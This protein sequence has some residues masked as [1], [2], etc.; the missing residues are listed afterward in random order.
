MS[1]RI[2]VDRSF[3]SAAPY[4]LLSAEGEIFLAPGGLMVGWDV[5]SDDYE[6]TSRA[7]VDAACEQLAAAYQ[8]LGDGDLTHMIFHRVPA[9]HY[10]PREF[11]A[12]A[13][14]LIDDERRAAFEAGRY[15]HTLVRCYLTHVPEPEIRSRLAASL[16]SG[17]APLGRTAWRAIVDQFHERMLSFEDALAGALRVKR[18]SSAEMFQDLHLCLTGLDHPFALP[19]EPVHLNEVLADQTFYGGLEPAVGELYLRPV[20]IDAYPSETIPQMLGL[21][22]SHPGRLMLSVRFICMDSYTAQRQLRLARGHWARSMLGPL[23]MVLEAMNVP[24]RRVNQ[25]AEEMHRDSSEAIAAASAGTP[26]GFCT[27]TAVVIDE[28]IQRANL[29]A[30]TL[31][32]SLRNSGLGARVEDANAVEAIKGTWPGVGWHNVRRPLLT[33]AISLI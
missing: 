23:D 7:E 3:A 33:P 15:W 14:A 1:R 19:T 29:R 21:I 24:R 13:A 4:G 22:L 25:D 12:R 16:F 31:V 2:P 18:L 17:P 26:F 11:P 8:H 6:S 10:P 28:D 9:P 32:R 5:R 30:R 20:S 27:V